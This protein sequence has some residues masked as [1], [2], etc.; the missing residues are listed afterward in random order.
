MGHDRLPFHERNTIVPQSD[1]SSSIE[2]SVF[3][4][5]AT[6]FS[7]KLH[8]N[9][10]DLYRTL[11]KSSH[12]ACGAYVANTVRYFMFGSACLYSRIFLFQMCSF[13]DAVNC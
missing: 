3:C 8:H 10:A 9:Q 7:F 5:V 11:I 13:N 12:T 1:T 4:S 2:G 6:R